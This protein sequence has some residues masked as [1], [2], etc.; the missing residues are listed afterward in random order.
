VEGGR[1]EAVKMRYLVSE[2]KPVSAPA[3]RAAPRTAAETAETLQTGVASAIAAAY[4][5]AMSFPE[6]LAEIPNLSFAQRQELVR[7]AIATDGEELTS[8][9]TAI[10]D[11]RM[12]DFHRQPDAGIPVEQLEE[13]VRERLARR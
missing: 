7:R 2:P 10:L 4:T 13:R 9:E 1:P 12:E 3:P 5:P 8:E 11:A 6:I